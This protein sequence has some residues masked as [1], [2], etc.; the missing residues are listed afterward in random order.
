MSASLNEEIHLS[1]RQKPLINYCEPI[2]AI[3]YDYAS[4]AVFLFHLT[5]LFPL[6]IYSRP[7][8][9]EINQ[10]AFGFTDLHIVIEI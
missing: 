7:C 10:V 3:D 5:C 6:R 2:S 1:I 4:H 9:S 8:Q